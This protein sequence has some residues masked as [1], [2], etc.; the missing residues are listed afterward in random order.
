MAS[1]QESEEYDYGELDEYEEDDEEAQEF[2]QDEGA[3]G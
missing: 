3:H 2:Y 1:R